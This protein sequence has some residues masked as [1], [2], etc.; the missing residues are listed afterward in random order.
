MLDDVREIVCPKWSIEILGFL[1]KNSPQNYSDIAEEFD[2][3]SDII[4]NR[5]QQLVDTGLLERDER[6]V[7]DVQYSITEDG[8]ELIKILEDADNLL[9]DQ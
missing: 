9:D 6:S 2:T 8:E 5:L 4:V 3:S 7:K 1:A